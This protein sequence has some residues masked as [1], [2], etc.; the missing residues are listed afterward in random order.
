M[1]K[2]KGQQAQASTSRATASTGSVDVDIRKLTVSNSRAKHFRISECVCSTMRQREHTVIHVYS[3][4]G[5]SV[6]FIILSHKHNLS[7]HIK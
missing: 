1:E 4:K 5:I 6:L 7:I 3:P 2:G